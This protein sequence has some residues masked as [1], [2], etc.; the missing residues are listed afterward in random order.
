MQKRTGTQKIALES[1]CSSGRQI[2]SPDCE[3][4][5]RKVRCRVYDKQC[6]GPMAANGAAQH[7]LPRAQKVIYASASPLR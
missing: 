6:E 1:L 4:F 2:C 3:A 5:L 7:T